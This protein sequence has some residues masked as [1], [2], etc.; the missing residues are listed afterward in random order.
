MGRLTM[1]DVELEF[2]NVQRGRDGRPAYYYFRRNGRRW[3]LPG[4]LLSEEFMVEYRRLKEET[5]VAEQSDPPEDR[6][7]FPRGTFGRLV[8]DY[9]AS[10][11]FKVGKGKKKRKSARTK[12]SYERLCQ[13]LQ[14]EHGTKRVSRLER[15]H[16]RQIR[17]AKADTPGEANNILRMLK[18]LL[19]FAVD[20]GLIQASPASRFKE[21]PTGEWRSWTDE[22]CANSR[23]DGRLGRCSVEPICSPSTPASVR[24]TWSAG[25]ER[26]AGRRHLRG[27]VQ[28]RQGA[29]DTGAQ[30]A[31][32]RARQ[33]VIGIDTL[34]V[35]PVARQALLIGVLRRLVR[36]GDRRRRPARRLCSPWPAQDAPPANLPSSASPPRTSSRSPAMSPA[37]WSKST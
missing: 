8:S 4:E 31:D 26:T 5:D 3:R 27:A 34:L 17:D 35:T 19:N 37:A 22:E 30:G 9:L 33:G 12:A 32:G 29:L 36:R 23:S 7:D 11:E 2:L 24:P 13:M 25:R 15:R 21:L 14:R 10:G 16:V 18:I 6:L 20:D 28:D 1:A